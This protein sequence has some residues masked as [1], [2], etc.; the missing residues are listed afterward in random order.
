MERMNLLAQGVPHSIHADNQVTFG[1]IYCLTMA[2][3]P[4]NEMTKPRYRSLIIT[5]D[6][7][8]MT[9]RNE[10]HSMLHNLS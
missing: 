6:Y 4:P 2:L 9:R 7:E 10:I 8:E 5:C 3:A 1:T